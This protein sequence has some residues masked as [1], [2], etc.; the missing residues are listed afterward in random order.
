MSRHAYLAAKVRDSTY[1]V[2]SLSS[3]RSA[4]LRCALRMFDLPRL[5]YPSMPGPAIM[6]GR[7]GSL[8]SARTSLMKSAMFSSSDRAWC[9][10]GISRSAN[11]EGPRFDWRSVTFVLNPV[12]LA[13]RVAPA[14]KPRKA[15]DM[16]VVALRLDFLES[17][18]DGPHHIHVYSTCA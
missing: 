15:S 1:I 3:G 5:P 11:W 8:N 13:G 10:H 16:V 18:L 17:I 4:T 2:D 12:R 7:A 6:K 9:E 14:L